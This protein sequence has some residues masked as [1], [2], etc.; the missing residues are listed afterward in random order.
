MALILPISADSAPVAIAN[1]AEIV[2]AFEHD[3]MAGKRGRE[4]RIGLRRLAR[5]A[6]EVLP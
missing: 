6:R 1:T 5:T 2:I 3:L 4:S